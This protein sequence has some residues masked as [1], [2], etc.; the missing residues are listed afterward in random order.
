LNTDENHFDWKAGIDYK[1]TESMMAYASAA[2][3]YRPQ[4]F[5]RV[6]PGDAVRRRVE[7]RRPV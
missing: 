2:T 7:K 4:A 3:S 1:F 6:L 5:N